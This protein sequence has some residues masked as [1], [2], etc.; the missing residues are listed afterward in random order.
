M[1]QCFV[2]SRIRLFLLAFHQLLHYE[3][4]MLIEGNLEIVHFVQQKMAR[5]HQRKV[6]PLNGFT[7]LPFEHGSNTRQFMRQKFA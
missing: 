1:S 4:V 6:I 2:R 7:V 5:S 3:L